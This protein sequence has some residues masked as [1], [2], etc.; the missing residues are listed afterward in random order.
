M[1]LDDKILNIRTINLYKEM[2]YD[3]LKESFPGLNRDE[4]NDAI[5]Y[6]ISQRLYNGPAYI[7]NNYTKNRING[8]VLDILNYIQSLEPIMTSSGVLFKKH[9]E[10][11]NPLSKMIMGFISKRKDYK[12]IMFKFPKGTS[13]FEKYNLL[14]SL[15]KID[16]NGIG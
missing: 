13:E 14:Q 1:W 2:M 9:K 3:G 4:L 5:D 6:S 7:N 15:D 10:M 16:A 8:T 11:D 12:K